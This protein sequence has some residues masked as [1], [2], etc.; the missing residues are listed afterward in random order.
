VTQD[1]ANDG[2]R[3][4]AIRGGIVTF[5]LGKLNSAGGSVFQALQQQHRNLP[6]RL[7]STEDA[8]QCRNG[9]CWLESGGLLVG[10]G[11]PEMRSAGVS[12]ATRRDLPPEDQFH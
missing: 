6:I 11:D 12:M 7:T 9:G 10:R 5:S 3:G 8:G 4:K 2:N 1:R